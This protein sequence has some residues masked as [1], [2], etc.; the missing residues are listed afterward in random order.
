LSTDDGTRVRGFRG[1]DASAYQVSVVAGPDAGAAVEVSAFAPSPTL[2]GQST[3]CGLRLRDPE[4]SRRHLSL[5]ATPLGLEIVD[6]RS[7]NGVFVNGVR[8]REAVLVGGERVALGSSALE[9]AATG[10]RDA[11]PPAA[12]GFGRVLGQSPEMRRI[13]PLLARLAASTTPLVIEGETGTGKELVA[14]S[15]HEASPRADGPFIV[16]DCTAVPANLLESALFG[17]E[18]GAFTGAVQQKKG[19]FELAHGGTLFLDEIGDLELSLQPKLLRALERS[20]VGRVGSARWEK[21][22][23]RVLAATRRDLDREVQL[24]RFRDDLFYRLAITRVELPPLRR[25]T[26]DVGFLARHFWRDL[27]GGGQPL[28]VALFQRFE[29]HSWPGNVREL[30][31]AIARRIALGDMVDDAPGLGGPASRPVEGADVMAAILAEDLP[32]TRARQ[33][34]VDEF[35]RRY[36]ERVLAKHGGNVTH[37]AATSGIARR[38]FNA[39]RARLVRG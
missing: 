6:L 23:V 11:P 35:E 31:N 14:E 26:G 3:A 2:V 21:V 17:H 19:V 22:D 25:R 10:R 32:L 18:K 7:T 37:A 27:G 8:V 34:V 39:I 4:V 24:G 16:F 36:I 12:T 15:L 9:I 20:E 38:Y 28:P 5:S 13:Y 29:E 33:K 30:R 1:I